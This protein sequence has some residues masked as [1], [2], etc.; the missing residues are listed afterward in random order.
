MGTGW[1]TIGI[2]QLQFFILYCH[3][4]PY[5]CLCLCLC[6]CLARSLYGVALYVVIRFCAT[7]LE[8]NEENGIWWHEIVVD[9]RD[10]WNVLT[11][12]SCGIGDNECCAGVWVDANNKRVCFGG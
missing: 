10:R 12:T 4:I 11:T 3:P 2:R 7:E 6:L 8:A 5:L 1:S 9:S